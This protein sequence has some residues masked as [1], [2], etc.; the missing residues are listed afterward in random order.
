M[1]AW[2]KLLHPDDRTRADALN[3]AVIRGESTYEGE[4][5]LRHK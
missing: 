1:N 4:F 3:D 2:E 5:R